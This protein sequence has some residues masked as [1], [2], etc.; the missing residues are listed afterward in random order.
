M[1]RLEGGDVIG[2]FAG[3]GRPL[4][5]RWSVELCCGPAAFGVLAARWSWRAR[6]PPAGARGTANP[7]PADLVE[8]GD[9]SVR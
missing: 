7:A 2:L 8:D 3:G 1:W 5:R 9:G 6:L 4:R